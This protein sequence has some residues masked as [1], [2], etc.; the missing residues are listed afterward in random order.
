MPK[1]DALTLLIGRIRTR[2]DGLS[3][4]FRFKFCGQP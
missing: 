3:E 2:G 1:P 4:L